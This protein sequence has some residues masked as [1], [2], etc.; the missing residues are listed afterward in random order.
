MC[1]LNS[2]DEVLDLTPLQALPKLSSLW[3]EGSFDG[4][5]SLGHLTHL[6]C[7]GATVDC[8]KSCKFMTALQHLDL[9]STTL[10]NFDHRGLSVCQGLRI[11]AMQTSWVKGAHSV[12]YAEDHSYTPVGMSLLTKLETLS[13]VCTMHTAGPISLAWVSELTTLRDFDITHT[14]IDSGLIETLACLSRLTKLVV[15]GLGP[16]AAAFDRN[17]IPK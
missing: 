13:L 5:A 10:D 16:P 9:S 3:L 4:L 15:T 12:L 14:N 7:S 8:S 1:F 2:V 6:R 11:L 17:C